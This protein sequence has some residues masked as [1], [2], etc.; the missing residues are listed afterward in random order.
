MEK[1]EKTPTPEDDLGIV[2]AWSDEEKL[3]MEEVKHCKQAKELQE[4]S[5]KANDILIKVYEKR[6]K[7]IKK[8]NEA[9]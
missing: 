8:E 1:P 2:I 9:G 4:A 6:L 5:I 3:L 7:E